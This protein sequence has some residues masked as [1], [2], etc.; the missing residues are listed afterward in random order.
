MTIKNFVV[1][2]AAVLLL[3]A[4]AWANDG[5]ERN[6]EYNKNYNVKTVQTITGKVLEIDRN[7]RPLK[8]MI[9]GFSAVVQPAKGDPIRV[10]IGPN[11]FTSYYRQQ[12]NTQVGDQVTLTGSVVNL[13]GQRVM[14]VSQG[15]KGEHKL[16]IR[17]SQGSPVWDI[18]IAGF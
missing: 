10:Q 11:W 13:N 18:Q 2:A 6:S 17:D 1:N 7:Y 4:P 12:W 5:W 16:T 3:A 15:Q 8:G 9:P 14:L